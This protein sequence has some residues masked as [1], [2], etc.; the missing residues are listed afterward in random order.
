MHAMLTILGTV[1]IEVIS[2]DTASLITLLNRNAVPVFNVKQ[3]GPLGILFQV[4]RKDFKSVKKICERRGDA[5]N[6][7]NRN[8]FYWLVKKG[9][10][11]TAL[12]LGIGL[13]LG[14]SAFLP[15]RILFIEVVG[16]QHI[17]A[18]SI[19]ENAQTCGI[20]FFSSRSEIRSEQMKNKLLEAMPQLQWAGI[21]TYGSRAVISVSEKTD[22]NQKTVP[23]GIYSI[24]AG[25]DG[26]VQSCTATKGNL[27]C[28]KGQAVKK[29]EMLISGYTDCG[30]VIQ[31]TKAEGEIYA[32][33]LRNLSMVVPLDYT[34]K[35]EN[36]D[37]EQS[38][39]II[40]GK[41]RIKLW[42][43]SRISPQE[44]VKIYKEYTLRLPGGF[45]LPVS[46]AIEHWTGYNEN[47][48]QTVSQDF[49]LDLSSFA[50]TYLKQQM[51]SGTVISKVEN[52]D[53]INEILV[54][55]GQ[56]SCHEMIGRMQKEE[57][58]DG[59]NH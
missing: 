12:M 14:L 59:K 10:S 16:N 18:K 57:I 39:S 20:Q 34:D 48:I 11:R 45:M 23:D 56:Y 24:V 33:T 2:A 32:N 29:G 53:V 19:L 3:T 28:Q 30:L 1:T 58:I 5:V 38:F 31:A 15:T 44:C 51:L 43:N 35:T 26:V 17:P 13:T 42:G 54:F 9:V 41:I 25:V 55:N 36:K 4:Y 50:Q 40:F 21:N 22:Y 27:L 6:L 52:W 47:E 7:K 49:P 37:S 8:G 46:L